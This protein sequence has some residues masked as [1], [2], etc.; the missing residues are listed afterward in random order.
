MPRKSILLVIV[1]G[2]AD[3]SIVLEAVN[4]VAGPGKFLIKN[5]KLTSIQIAVLHKTMCKVFDM[6]LL[7]AKPLGFP[8][9]QRATSNTMANSAVLVFYALFYAL[10]T[11]ARV[12]R[13]LMCMHRRH[14]NNHADN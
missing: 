5:I 11:P 4:P 7:P 1:A 2:M 12:R 10:V 13:T 8:A 9:R 6:V 14:K 3:A